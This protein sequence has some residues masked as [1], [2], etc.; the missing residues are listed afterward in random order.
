MT[1]PPSSLALPTEVHSLSLGLDMFRNFIQT[2]GGILPK[3]GYG[4]KHKYLLN[5][6]QSMFMFIQ[7]RTVISSCIVSRLNEYLRNVFER[8]LIF[9]RLINDTFFFN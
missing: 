3:L 2:D 9:C 7:H 1:R 6:S 8:H 4:H 5:H